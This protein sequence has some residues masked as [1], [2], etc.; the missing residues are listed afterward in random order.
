MII[1]HKFDARSLSN[2]IYAYGLAD[3]VIK[4]DDDSTLFD[5]FAEQVI[6]FDKLTE[7]LPQHLSNMLWAYANVGVSN[8]QLFEQAGN[9]IVDRNNLN[10]FKPQEF[11]N[12]IW[13]HATLDEQHKKL[14]EKVGDH[15]TE[16]DSLDKFWPQALLILYGHMPH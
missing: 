13:A 3:Y 7:F 5:V 12:I 8:F 2:L 6:S 15:I 1:L 4:F 10:E 14:F 11:S 16:L 9:T